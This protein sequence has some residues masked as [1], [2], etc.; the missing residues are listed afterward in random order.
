[1]RVARAGGWLLARQRSKPSFDTGV[2]PETIV[3]QNKQSL[4]DVFQAS[5]SLAWSH[6]GI[7]TCPSPTK[8]EDFGVFISVC[9]YR[10]V[11]TR[12]VCVVC[13]CWVG[14]RCMNRCYSCTQMRG[15]KKIYCDFHSFFSYLMCEHPPLTHMTLCKKSTSQT[16]CYNASVIRSYYRRAKNTSVISTY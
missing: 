3:F 13:V 15:V 14:I 10:F 16:R 11:C 5:A 6:K 8:S 4:L 12:V 1:V 7:V 9:S 2:S